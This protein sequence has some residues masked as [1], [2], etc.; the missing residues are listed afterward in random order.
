MRSG[1]LLR[2]GDVVCALEMTDSFAERIRGLRGR[3]DCEGALHM[4][5]ARA[6]HS[7]G[8]GFALDVAFLT[9][10]LV[11]IK[12]VRLAPW[13]I[14]LPRSGVRSVLQARAGALERWGVQLHDQLEVREVR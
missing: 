8:M 10:D 11:V 13:R 6:V 2:D 12:M 7:A 1:W 4:P 5:G 14:A 3:D 9:G